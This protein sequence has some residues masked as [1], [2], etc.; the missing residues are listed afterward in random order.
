MTNHAIYSGLTWHRRHRPVQHS[1]EYKIHLFWLDLDQLESLDQHKY[2]GYR[3][4]AP[5]RFRR[6][7]YLDQPER[8]LKEVALEAMTTCD[9][10]QL[11]GKVF[12]LGQLRFF[13]VLFSPVNFYYRQ[14]EQGQFT[15]MLAEVSNTPWNER[16]RYVVDLTNPQ[17]TSKAFHVSPF[18]PM[19][20][21]YHW[22]VPEPDEKLRLSI[23]L[24]RET[25]HFSAGIDLSR[26][27]MNPKQLWRVMLSTMS[28][29]T[30]T[31][32]YWQALKL[33][34]KGAPVYSHPVSGKE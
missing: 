5:V 13:G 30:I 32:I 28:L 8:S 9:G 6:S 10:E 26:L 34:G 22:Q 20:M 21:T 17:P 25:S 27:P 2:L 16:H 33:F 19:D 24:R 1:F 18:N 14:N 15:H 29:K 12:L 4:W 11:S 31:G 23:D 7:D 3:R